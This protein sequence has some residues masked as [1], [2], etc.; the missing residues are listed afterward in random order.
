MNPLTDFPRRKTSG[1]LLVAYIDTSDGHDALNLGI[2]LARERQVTLKLVSVVSPITPQGFGVQTQ[3]PGYNAIVR[4]QTQQRLTAALESLPSDISATWHVV[5]GTD[6]A[7]ALNDAAQELECDLIIVGARSG[8]LLNRFRIGTVASSLLYTA[9]VPVA[10]AP[11]GYSYPG[12]ITGVSALVGPRQG[13][14]DVAAI[15]LDRAFRREVPLRII[16]LKIS[17]EDSGVTF[18]QQLS[19]AIQDAV[20]KGRA[21]RITTSGASVQSA[22]QNLSWKE[23]EV[24]VLGSARIAS[25]GRLFLGATANRILKHVPV[26]T[27]VVPSGYMTLKGGERS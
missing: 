8:G 17:G 13:R 22:L 20:S 5:E 6:P 3:D 9:Q 25:E 15:G 12:P 14:S 4:K 2:A 10:L 16:T 1:S 23:G 7:L 24:A 18:E 21:S 11:Q 26:P 19:E 27:I